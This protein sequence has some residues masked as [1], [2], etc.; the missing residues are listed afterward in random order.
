MCNCS[1]IARCDMIMEKCDMEGI[2]QLYT[3]SNDFYSNID[4]MI[5]NNGYEECEPGHF[6]GPAVRKSFMIHYI[7]EG[8]GIYKVNNKIYHLKRGD[9]FLIRPGEEIFYQAD[10]SN[11]WCY[12]WIGMQGVKIEAYLKRTTFATTPVIHY[13]KDDQLSFL[14]IKM[15][16]AYTSGSN[17]RDLLLNSVLY[18]LLHFLVD[19]FPNNECKNSNT[20]EDYVQEAINYCFTNLDKKI[21]VSDIAVHLGLNRSYLA[22]L[23][24]KNVGVSLKKY[25]L[26]IKLNEADKL[27]N[28]T[29]LPINIIA[30]S[31]GFDDPLY[32]SRLYKEKKGICA[33]EYRKC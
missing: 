22:R 33:K 27:L 10:Q 15:Q 30:R 18:E 29:T 31:I 16:K 28:E 8:R 2:M 1:N 5:Y 7:T 20:E 14:Y 12:G 11:P 25:I 17:S 26:K 9:A 24:K 6:Y 21:Q 23:F 19:N 4:A 13:S 3:N 32:F